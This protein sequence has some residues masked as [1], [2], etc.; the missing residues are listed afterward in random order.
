MSIVRLT[1]KEKSGLSN[2]DRLIY[3]WRKYPDIFIRDWSSVDLT[4]FQRITVRKS[5][6]SKFNYLLWSRGL[7][8]TS[9]GGLII[10]T[11]CVLYPGSKFGILAPAYRQAEQ[12]FDYMESYIYDSPLMKDCIITTNSNKVSFKKQYEAKV[13]FK[14]ASVTKAMPLGD[15]NKIRG[16]RFT[17]VW[18]EEFAQIEE[19]VLNLS[20]FPMLNIKVKGRENNMWF[21]T[22]AYFSFNH[23]YKQYLLFCLEQMNHNKKYNLSEYTYLDHLKIQDPPYEYDLDMLERQK[24]DPTMTQE[25]FEMEN[26][27]KFPTDSQGLFSAR[28][29]DLCTPR[30]TPLEPEL[31]GAQDTR[32]FYTMGIDVART[33]GGDNFAICILKCDKISKTRQLVY[34]F[35]LNGAEYPDEVLSIRR[36]LSVFPNVVRIF[37]DSQGGGMALKDLLKDAWTDL[38][39]GRYCPPILDIDDEKYKQISGVR[40]LRMFP[41]S[42]PMNNFMYSSLKAVMEK[43][44]M[45][46]PLDVLKSGDI[47]KDRV[48]L[49]IS[50]AK[51][52]LYMIRAEPR[53][54]LFHFEVPR[55]HKKDRATALG[56]AN[57]AAQE[58]FEEEQITRDINSL[59]VGFW[60]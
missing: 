34:C 10:P 20:I 7:G 58:M 18:L 32:F 1:K 25:Q 47:M 51:K 30:I 22:T 48:A 15:G 46:F 13:N 24:N 59:G 54:T 45:G 44:I 40:I 36:L 53:G 17:D 21:S 28:L 8:K 27:C 11:K 41:S 55:G 14:N 31:F 43:R 37:M 57:L 56:L 60:M 38:L 3:F 35:A 16:Q 50:R 23:A 19:E 4:W 5:L 26:L 29:I 9:F 33:D 12:V 42:Q 2:F 49:E 6:F 52:E 39:T